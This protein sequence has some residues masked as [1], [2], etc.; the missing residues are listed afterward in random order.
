VT[1]FFQMQ[2]GAG[3]SP[4]G[5]TLATAPRRAAERG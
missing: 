1:H 4:P 5:A 3:A 2:V